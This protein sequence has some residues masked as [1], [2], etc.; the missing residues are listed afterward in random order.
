MAAKYDDRW[1]CESD[2][3]WICGTAHDEEEYGGDVGTA[4]SGQVCGFHRSGAEIAAEGWVGNSFSVNGMYNLR[5]AWV[6]HS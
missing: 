6:G 1:E 2:R 3:G 4:N 5:I